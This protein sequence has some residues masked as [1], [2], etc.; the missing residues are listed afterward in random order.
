[1]GFDD[2]LYIRHATIGHLDIVPIEELVE[3]MVSGKM[4]FNEIQESS[5]NVSF[6]IVRK[7]RV[8][9]NYLPLS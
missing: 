7:W 4:F 2:V 8:E 6:Y 1:V 9:P 3:P 5:A